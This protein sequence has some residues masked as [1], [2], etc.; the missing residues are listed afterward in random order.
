MWRNASIASA[1]RSPS[2]TLPS[3]ASAA[4]DGRVPARIGHDGH[5]GM[6][7]RRGADHRRT[8]DVDLLDERVER[9]PGPIGGR[10]ERV[11]IHDDELER[12]DRR[13]HELLPMVDQP[14]VGED[15]GVNPR[16]ERLDP[17]VEHLREAGHGRD[18]GHRQAR[19]AE[20][21]SGPA[22]RHELEAGADEPAP[23]LHQAG[24]VADR[25]ESTARDR[26]LRLGPSDIDRDPA[27]VRRDGQRTGERQRHGPREESMLHRPDAVMERGLVV[28][29]HDR[30]GLLGDDRAAV[31]RGVDEMDRG[32]ADRDPVGERIP[33]GVSARERGEQRRVRVEDPAR[34]GS[35]DARADDPH[36]AGEHDQLD[37]GRLQRFGEGG[38]V[39]GPISW[40]LRDGR[41]HERRVD[42]LLGRP[43]ERGTGAIG[44]DEDD[45]PAELGAIRRRS[46]RAQVRA[47]ARDTDG[48][49]SAGL[50]HRIAP[51]T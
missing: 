6:V 27:R 24:L 40:I 16:M 46:Q 17:S 31:E 4:E 8:A 43:V 32:A 25:Q 2:G 28:A 33:H 51:S 44:E 9:D 19:L 18:V 22:G 23:E 35:Q 20:R 42:P 11:E 30:H 34:E 38:I 39:R 49:P 1:D 50:G 12:S 15:P 21:S 3:S 37:G 14:A 29:G 45:R 13:R 41:G 10:G 48:D 47:R 7:L 26:H 36:V 5:A